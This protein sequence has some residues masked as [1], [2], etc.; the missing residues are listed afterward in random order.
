MVSERDARGIVREL[1][2]DRMVCWGLSSSGLSAGAGGL[3]GGGG[4]LAGVGLLLLPK[5]HIVLVL[6][7]IPQPEQMLY[8]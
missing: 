4:A 8:D 6:V 7:V 3:G 2:P 5:K 1:T